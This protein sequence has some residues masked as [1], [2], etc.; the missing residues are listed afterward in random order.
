M[1]AQNPEFEKANAA[2]IGHVQDF[3]AAIITLSD[4]FYNLHFSLASNTTDSNGVVMTAAAQ[5]QFQEKMEALDKS[6]IE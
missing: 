5:A 3:E 4:G 2:Y 1:S 6:I